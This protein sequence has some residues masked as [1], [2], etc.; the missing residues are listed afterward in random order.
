MIWLILAVELMLVVFGYRLGRDKN[1]TVMGILLPLFF[2]IFGLLVVVLLPPGKPTYQVVSDR[3]E[4]PHT[5]A[6]RRV[7]LARG[8]KMNVDDL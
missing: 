4:D 8:L 1:Q 2:S 7:K 5:Q 3:P 6:R